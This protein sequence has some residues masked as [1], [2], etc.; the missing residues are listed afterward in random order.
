MKYIFLVTEKYVKYA[1]DDL[2]EATLFYDYLI[3]N[4]G[5]SNIIITIHTVHIFK[6]AQE[7]IDKNK[8]K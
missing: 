7:L 3:K 5:D 2:K 8:F 6:N 4:K 1:F